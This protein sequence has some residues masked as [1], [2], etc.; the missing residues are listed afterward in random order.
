MIDRDVVVVGQ[1]SQVRPPGDPVTGQIFDEGGRRLVADLPEPS[2]VAE[3]LQAPDGTVL[4]VDALITRRQR[5]EARACEWSE[6]AREAGCP[7]DSP[8]VVGLLGDTGAS[9]IR[10]QAALLVRV[11]DGQFIEPTG[12]GFRLFD[13]S[14]S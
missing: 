13:P 6:A 14:N 5:E 10:S 4:V 7:S 9:F 8:T 12:K 1:V 3:A 2:T 11:V